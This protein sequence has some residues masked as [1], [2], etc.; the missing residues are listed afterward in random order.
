MTIIFLGVMLGVVAFVVAAIRRKRGCALMTLP[1]PLL[2]ASWFVLASIA[3]N[4]EKEFDRLFGGGFRHLA[5]D[6]QTVKPIF[7]DG[8]LI[9]FHTSE[10][11]YNAMTAT[12][13][14]EQ[15]LGG[16][17]FFR[18]GIRP[19]SWPVYLETLDTFDRRDIGDDA[20]FAHFD[21]ETRTVYAAYHIWGW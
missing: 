10:A 1:F 5:T 7:M 6:I 2:V 3:P 9:T 4:A 18:R 17:R 15:P 14:S 21:K 11:D 12:T 20:V 8:F 16:R 13:F 19:S